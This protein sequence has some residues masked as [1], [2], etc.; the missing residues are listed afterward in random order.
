V[1][2]VKLDPLAMSAISVIRHRLKQRV[3]T[4]GLGDTAVIG[5]F[6]KLGLDGQIYVGLLMQ[7]FFLELKS[8]RNRF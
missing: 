2:C 6:L 8:K 1:V 7:G 5:L 4:L 3:T